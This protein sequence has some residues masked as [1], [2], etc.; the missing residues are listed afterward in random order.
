LIGQLF[1]LGFRRREVAYERRARMIGKSAWRF[2]RRLRY[3]LDSIFAFSDFPISVLLWL[4]TLGI[5][6]ATTATVIVVSAWL[7]GLI[8]VRGY[9]P[10]MLAIMFFGSLLIFGQG[11][12]GCYVWRVSENTKKRPSSIVLSHRR[13]SPLPRAEL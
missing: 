8:E 5:L 10:M 3:M 2:R 9:V 6:V 4:G 11:V 1:W 7:L 13:G 12:I